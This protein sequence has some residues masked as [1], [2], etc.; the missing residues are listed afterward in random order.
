VF[1][2]LR[3][4]ELTSVG[5]IFWC[6]CTL[7]LA[8]MP[9]RGLLRFAFLARVFSFH[10]SND[11]PVETP[12]QK[13]G[14]YSSYAPAQ[15]HAQPPAP[16][17]AVA[18]RLIERGLTA[19]GAQAPFGAPPPPAWA[20]PA[21]AAAPLP[22]HTVSLR[23]GGRAWAAQNMS[24]AFLNALDPERLLFNF[25]ATANLSTQ[26]ARSYGGWESADC[27]LRGHIAGG[28]W[29]SGAALLVNA[30][31]GGGALA[32]RASHV[33]AELAKCQAANTAKGW[34]GYLSAFPP[35]HF[36]R[37]ERNIQPI[38]APY[39]TIHKILQGLL[40]MHT[41]VGDPNAAQIA[42][43]MIGYFATRIRDLIAR[44]T[45]AQWYAVMNIEHG[46]MNDVC[47]RWFAATGSADAR[48]LAE[49]FDEPCWLGPL[50]LQADV[51]TDEHA[52][53]HLPVVIGAATQY[54]GTGDVRLGLAAT[55]FYAALQGAHTF[56]TGGS[57]SGE[58]WGRPRR[59]GDQLDVNGVES[60]STYNA[61]KLSRQLFGW[62]ADPAY[63]DA[64]ERAKYSGMFGTQHP[65]RVGAII[66]LM[67]L[68]GPDGLAGGSKA[69]TYWGWSDAEESMW[70]CVGSA[71][72][73]HS[74]HG[75]SLFFAGGA[76]APGVAP[77]L[78]LALYENAVAQWTVPNSSAG[79]T[80]TVD[81]Q[82][83]AGGLTAAVGV[84]ASGACAFTLAL[85]IP[86]WG[87]AGGEATVGGAPLPATGGWFNFSRS[88][89]AGD[90]ATVAVTLPYAPMLEP[91][92][93]DRP[94]FSNYYAVA[95]GPFALGAL[96]RV[97]NVIV[98]AN[99]TGA[100]VPWVRPLSDAE[101]A[102]AVSLAAPGGGALRH[103]N[104]T[105][106]WVGSA[107]GGPPYTPA[108]DEGPGD[109]TWI[110]EPAPSAPQL[111]ALRSLNRPGE[112]LTC[113]GA[114]AQCAIAHGATAAFNAS[115]AFVAHSPGLTGAPGTLSLEAA[116]LPGHFLSTLSS[117]ANSST[118]GAAVALQAGAGGAFA[119][120]ST[121][122]KGG[123]LW[124]PP[125]LTY[126]ATTGDNSVA[127][128]RDLL[129]LPIADIV[130]EYY[131]VYLR[132]E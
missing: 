5:V 30:T 97:D 61:L 53:T 23:P 63:L 116:A 125:P 49:M 68:R 123:A 32:A 95:V 107:A 52:N 103:D 60:C 44:E 7:L 84:T 85:R 14:A 48:Y 50:S 1:L 47:W 74:K 78:Y 35:D 109:A 37:L 128:S 67:P 2:E 17:F 127:G 120:A 12:L 71:L 112:R 110:M 69:H 129:L 58:W 22:L 82:W 21:L 10:C 45:I 81:A 24:A 98:G 88:W 6:A 80:V 113:G 93:D 65:S 105:G 77:T 72:E 126:V 57:S 73:S 101:R 66:Y 25:R 26:G 70:C 87:A 118:W 9:M 102:A 119:E 76:P 40:D 111:V 104:E 28:H 11:A 90:S 51:L 39:Y 62:G 55:G 20:P 3:G 29:L 92:N 130:D 115:A 42:L 54:E 106:V 34:P 132:V 124:T 13:L 19:L 91:L 4:L 117:P 46:G 122:K 114:G 18:S 100:P 16:G 56:A 83:S 89:S 94:S 108:S 8:R 131:G 86:S 36:D 96:T 75:D 79:V 31:G 41:L 121:F 15:A 27:L 59:L 99:A 43:G 38:W 64:F 33:V